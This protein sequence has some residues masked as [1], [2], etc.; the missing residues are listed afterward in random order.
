[1]PII[2]NNKDFVPEKTDIYLLA[3]CA[4]YMNQVQ[5]NQ[6]VASFWGGAVI[7]L[8]GSLSVLSNSPTI[9]ITLIFMGLL[10]ALILFTASLLV[11]KLALVSFRKLRTQINTMLYLEDSVKLFVAGKRFTELGNKY[12]IGAKLLT[13]C[14]IIMYVNV[15]C[16]LVTIVLLPLVLFIW[17]QIHYCCPSNEKID[18][19]KQVL[20]QKEMML[21]KISNEV[22]A[23]I[24]AIKAGI[25]E[26]EN[27]VDVDEMKIS[28]TTWVNDLQA[29]IETFYS[30][31]EISNSTHKEEQIKIFLDLYQNKI[32]PEKCKF[33]VIQTLFS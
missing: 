10:F 9:Q 32:F 8:L 17:W 26:G 16:Y 20:Y 29:L 13:V 24:K 31:Y 11:N 12:A 5:D 7:I 6:V 22:D 19:F 4:G 1:M 30:L 15:V 25:S 14:A 3:E 27:A 18:E 21:I 2:E 28:I 23:I 33:M